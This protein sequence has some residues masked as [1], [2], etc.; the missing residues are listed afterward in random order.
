VK[1]KHIDHE[2]EF[3]WGK[4]SQDYAKYRSGYPESFYEVLAALGIGKPR[5]TILD[6]GT[7]TGVLARA[8]AKRGARVTGVDISASQIAAAQ[9][10]AAHEGLDIS[11]RVCA[12]EDIAFSD[13]S[14]E[15]ISAGQSWLYFDAVVLIPKVLRLLVADGCLVLTHFAWL[16]HKD[17]IA[18]K[19]EEL[20]LQYNPEWTAAGYKGNIPPVFSWA[21][22]DFDLRTFHVME[23]PIPFTRETWRGRIRACRGIG[24]SLA[25]D[26]VERFDAEHWRLLE[27]I[28]PEAF[29]VL[30]QLAL[31]VYVRKGTIVTV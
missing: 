1:R 10:L 27:T 14:F 2:R 9:A 20:V 21:K 17:N 13:G 19:T 24:A 22:A 15:I 6:L 7:G 29:T 5:Q 25:A 16:P 30:H 31:H 28:A 4:T 8:F 18:Q 12:A 23:V 11:F 26:E 3:D